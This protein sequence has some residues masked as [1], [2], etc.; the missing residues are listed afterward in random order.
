MSAH[1]PP[2]AGS[3][4][5]LGLHA[6]HG[7][8]KQEGFLSGSFVSDFLSIQLP[9]QEVK[10]PPLLGFICPVQE[11]LWGHIWPRAVWFLPMPEGLRGR[12]NSSS[13]RRGQRG[14]SKA[15]IRAWLVPHGG[16]LRRPASLCLL[17][18]S[19]GPSY[20]NRPNPD[21]VSWLR[22]FFTIFHFLFCLSEF[23]CSSA[24]D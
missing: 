15:K 16:N 8:K 9:Q 14:G 2:L 11:L 24:T 4:D 1:W 10:C 7:R 18:A 23:Y 12:Q 13:Y 6:A 20:P 22:L 5:G 17:Q 19:G 21:A 3:K